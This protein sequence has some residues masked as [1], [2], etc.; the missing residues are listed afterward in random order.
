MAILNP[1][2]VY[3]WHMENITI[4]PVLAAQD[5]G[6]P[7]VFNIGDYWLS[8]LKAELCLEPNP[9]K[10]KYRAIILGLSNFNRINLKY[11]LVNSRSLRRKYVE[12]GFAE[13]NITVIPRGILSDLI[14]DGESFLNKSKSHKDQKDDVKLV[15]VGRLVSEKGPDVAIKALAHAIHDMDIYNIHLDIFGTGTKEYLNKLQSI[16]ATLQL[17]EKVHFSGQL[18]HQQL[19]KRYQN[20]DMLLFTSRWDEPFSTII[21]EAMARGLPVIATN[22]GSVSEVLT[23]GLNGLVVPKDEP[24]ALARAIRRMIQENGL[25]QK[26]RLAALDTTRKK[27]TLAQ[28]VD[29]IEEYLKKV[30]PGRK[31]I[32]H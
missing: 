10:K 18:E 15:F 19:L 9:L 3:A 23:D 20:Y 30:M 11:I 31:Q 27:F 16:V 22:T 2:I 4:S 32:C 12:L 1:D 25:A 7:T 13:N 21:L 29:E 26:V 5:E 28:I 24:I 8:R 17:G 6:I 14:L